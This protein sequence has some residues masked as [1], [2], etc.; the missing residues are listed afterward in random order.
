M[1]L[2]WDPLINHPLSDFPFHVVPWIPDLHGSLDLRYFDGPPIAFLQTSP[3][4]MN[5]DEITCSSFGELLP[6]RPQLDVL[7]RAFT[8]ADCQRRSAS[9]SLN[10]K[11]SG[12][13]VVDASLR[14]GFARAVEQ[15][16]HH[17]LSGTSEPRDSALRA[18]IRLVSLPDE[19]DENPF[20]DRVISPLSLGH[21]D[22]FNDDV[23]CS[24][25]YKPRPGLRASAMIES[26]SMPF[27]D[28]PILAS[29]IFGSPVL[30]TPIIRKQRSVKFASGLSRFN[31]SSTPRL[32]SSRFVSPS[33]RRKRSVLNPIFDVT[34][35]VKRKVSSR[36]P[37]KS[38]HP[39]GTIIKATPPPLP[40]LPPGLERIG[41]GIGHTP[42]RSARRHA[43]HFP[44]TPQTSHGLLGR[45]WSTRWN[46]RGNI[47]ATPKTWDISS[48]QSVMED[49]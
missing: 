3:A 17:G 40:P 19:D 48:D 7:V 11:D 44:T 29:P 9:P 45:I 38:S 37:R 36:F 5:E 18:G 8:A 27:S 34:A 26:K 24:T 49:D 6:H 43:F 20:I 32:T 33:P 30:E 15:L 46:R 28:S 23:L 1:S 16:A 12:P 39:S 13:L 35:S 14:L 22:A 10:L 31:F 4:V 21:Q 41:H 42:K 47:P 2:S 25:P